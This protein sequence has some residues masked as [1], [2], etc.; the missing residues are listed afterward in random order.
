MPSILVYLA[1][2]ACMTTAVGVYAAPE[3]DSWEWDW[4][5]DDDDDRDCRSAAGAGASLRRG[6]HLG[7]GAASSCESRCE[8]DERRSCRD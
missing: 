6:V 8:R 4:R 3:F 2:T 1:V 5:D 7:A